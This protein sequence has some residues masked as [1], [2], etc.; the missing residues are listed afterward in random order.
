MPLL[1]EALFLR[2]SEPGLSCVDLED[3]PSSLRRCERWGR[4]ERVSASRVLTAVGVP[5]RVEQ[6]QRVPVEGGFAESSVRMDFD[7][8]LTA[9]GP[10]V[11]FE[12]VQV[13]LQGEPLTAKGELELGGWSRFVLEGEEL[14]E[15]RWLFGLAR[16]PVEQLWLLVRVQKAE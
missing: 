6:G 2:L 7:P 8:R 13:R 4:V 1:I 10:R 9:D 12:L 11:G 3:P 15:I 5:A 16:R 14:G